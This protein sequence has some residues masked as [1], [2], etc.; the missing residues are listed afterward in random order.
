MFGVSFVAVPPLC[1]LLESCGFMLS[2][3]VDMSIWFGAIG[4]IGMW[5]TF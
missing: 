2:T 3:L 1:A 5:T 4:F